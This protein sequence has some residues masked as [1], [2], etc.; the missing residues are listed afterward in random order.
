MVAVDIEPVAAAVVGELAAAAAAAG[1]H[2]LVHVGDKAAAALAAAAAVVVVPAAIALAA[3]SVVAAAAVG[4]AVADGVPVADSLSY[5]V[6]GVVELGGRVLVVVGDL[7]PAA[8]AAVAG[9]Q[10]CLR[11]WPVPHH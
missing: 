1:E 8:A 7:D 10:D 2:C 9:E 11:K 3:A 6:L 5:H 4:V